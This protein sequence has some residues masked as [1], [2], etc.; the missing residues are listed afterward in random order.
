V[1]IGVF[2]ALL[3]LLIALAVMAVRN[4]I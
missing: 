2:A 3:I 1:Y 4:P